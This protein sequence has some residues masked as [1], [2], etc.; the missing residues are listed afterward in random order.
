[1]NFL[2][3]AHL[4]FND[5]E[6]IIG[7]FIADS[8]KGKAYVN[9]AHKIK[10]GILLHR[11]IDFF[12][13]T[14]PL[15]IE[16]KNILKPKYGRYSAVVLDV[17]YDHFLIHNWKNY[18]HIAQNEFVL[19]FYDL[20]K[21]NHAIMPA[22]ALTVS[23]YMIEQDWINNYATLKGLEIT[24]QRMA[25]KFCADPIWQ[26]DIEVIANNYNIFNN[27]FNMFF[28]QLIAYSQIELTKLIKQ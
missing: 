23:K 20:L 8:V 27:L 4:S 7:N 22:K 9:Y 1:M 19:Q 21:T 28:P 25:K 11:K 17:L 12:T 2:A 6:I 16:S 15:N 3:H 26:N 5:K 10:A 13:D 18:S 14:H 24:Y